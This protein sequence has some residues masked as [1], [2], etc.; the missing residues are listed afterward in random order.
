M[1]EKIQQ[2]CKEIWNRI[3]R[4]PTYK[5]F[6]RK[7]DKLAGRIKNA[8]LGFFSSIGPVWNFMFL[9]TT[10]PDELD[11][12]KIRQDVIEKFCVNRKTYDRSKTRVY[13]SL[14]FTLCSHTSVI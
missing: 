12:D 9:K 5:K 14:D 11:S 13:F 3:S 8:L 2:F 6:L 1:R 10:D 7:R 4:T